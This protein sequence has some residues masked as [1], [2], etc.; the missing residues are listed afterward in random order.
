MPINFVTPSLTYR[1]GSLF[2]PR[3]SRMNP[4]KEQYFAQLLVSTAVVESPD[5]KLSNA[6]S[7]KRRKATS[8]RPS[9][10]TGC[11]LTRYACRFGATL[12]GKCRPASQRSST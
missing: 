11:S 3:T 10:A 7:K 4:D 6:R 9:T 1:Y 8:G 2:E 12:M 5:G